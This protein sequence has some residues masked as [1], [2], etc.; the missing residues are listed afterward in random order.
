MN[1]EIA[2]PRRN[3][4]VVQCLF[5][6][7]AILL[8]TAAMLQASGRVFWCQCGRWVPWSWDIWSQHNSQ[9]LIDP[10]FFTHVLHGIAIY[11]LLHWLWKSA[12]VATRFLAAVV[13][14][15]GWELLENSSLA[16]DR[17]REVT[18][19]QDYYGDS[20]S[21]SLFDIAACALGFLLAARMKPSWSVLFFVATELFLVLTIR[22]C[23][24]L[25]IVMLVYPF[26]A[27]KHWQMAH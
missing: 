10:Y 16:I 21:N 18:I 3:S 5:V 15:A 25:N 17:Y 13:L 27:I 9:H 7:A 12:P 23:L 26:D 20:I 8:T 22:D 6:F 2:S 11:G 14:E 1:D 4:R 19:S 24:T